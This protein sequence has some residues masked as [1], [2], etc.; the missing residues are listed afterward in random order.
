MTKCARP[1]CQQDRLS[2]ILV[3]VLCCFVPSVE[4]RAEEGD[5]Q[6]RR[7]D[8]DDGSDRERGAGANQ[9]VAMRAGR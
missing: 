8:R 6:H 9:P 3:H 7:Q 2:T 1:F 4:A 5:E